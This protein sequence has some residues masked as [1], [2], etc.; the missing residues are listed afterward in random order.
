MGLRRLHMSLTSTWPS[1]AAK[2]KDITKAAG[3]STD[4]IHLYGCWSSL[5]LKATAYGPQTFTWP[6][7]IADLTS[8]SR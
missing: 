3:R 7:G 5:K 1:K 6:L 2:P 8:P 4:Y